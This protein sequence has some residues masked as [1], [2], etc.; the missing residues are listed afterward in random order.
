MRNEDVFLFLLCDVTYMLENPYTSQNDVI[1]A[2][3]GAE[4]R[5]HTPHQATGAAGR[6]MALLYATTVLQPGGLPSP[7]QRH[8]PGA[9]PWYTDS[10]AQCSGHG[11]LTAVSCG[12]AVV[13]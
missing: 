11:T 5:P 12:P 1:K 2:Q 7:A 10:S 9:R 6:G 8:S 4:A 3:Q 13:H